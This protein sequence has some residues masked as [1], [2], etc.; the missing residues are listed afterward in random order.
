MITIDDFEEKLSPRFSYSVLK[1]IIE[2][3]KNR[4]KEIDSI[5]KKEDLMLNIINTYK[6]KE[7][8]FNLEKSIENKNNLDI[9]LANNFQNILFNTDI[10]RLRSYEQSVIDRIKEKTL[11]LKE[12]SKKMKKYFEYEV[13]GSILYPRYVTN[14]KEY[15]KHNMF[16][17]LNRVKVENY[18]HQLILNPSLEDIYL[19]INKLITKFENKQIDNYVISKPIFVQLKDKIH[20]YAKDEKTLSDYLLVLESFI[21]EEK[22]LVNK[23]ESLPLTLPMY[24]KYIG[25]Q[26]GKNYLSYNANYLANVID[27]ELLE[28]N[29]KIFDIDNYKDEII[30][31]I[32]ETENLKQKEK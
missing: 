8:N 9:T 31:S 12:D 21:E 4:Y 16:L 6:E 25:Y 32:L 15:Y 29:I 20:L 19:V 1:Y 14:G 27:R 26:K 22:E 23:F 11:K 24:N 28:R 18:E 13:S 17:D 3:Y 5:F 7:D 30:D 2:E 10:S